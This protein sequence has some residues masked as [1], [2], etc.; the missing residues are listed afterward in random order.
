MAIFVGSAPE[1]VDQS[2]DLK[3]KG[4]KDLVI[5]ETTFLSPGFNP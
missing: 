2:T 3:I 1:H 4:G 5:D